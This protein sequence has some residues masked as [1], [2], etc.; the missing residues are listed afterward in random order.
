MGSPGLTKPQTVIKILKKA[1][2]RKDVVSL[3]RLLFNSLEQTSIAVCPVV[4]KIKKVLSELGLEA[5]LMSGSG[6]AVF[7]LL[8]SRKE[9]YSKARQLK[10]RKINWDVFVAKTV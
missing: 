1:L 2:L 5:I 10:A 7:G 4:G 9:A 8:S 3:G 6:P